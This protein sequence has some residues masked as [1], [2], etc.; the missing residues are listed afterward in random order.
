MN[1]QDADRRVGDLGQLYLPDNKEWYCLIVDG[2]PCWYEA[3]TDYL[4][5]EVSG[6][7]AI[8]EDWEIYQKE[9]EIR[10]EKTGELWSHEDGS[11]GMITERYESSPLGIAFDNETQKRLSDI[12]LASGKNKTYREY[13]IHNKNGWTRLYPPVED[14]SVERIEIEGVSFWGCTNSAGVHIMAESPEELYELIKKASNEKMKMILEIP[15]DK[16]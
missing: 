1:I 7:E 10:P 5:R 9:T 8:R 15:K 4:Q 14:D 13:I 3:S 12:N 11:I 6:K 2:R 16:P